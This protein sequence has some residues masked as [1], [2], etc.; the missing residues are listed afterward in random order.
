VLGSIALIWW[1]PA[2]VTAAPIWV[3]N[4]PAHVNLHF[5]R[6]FLGPLAGEDPLRETVGWFTRPHVR[7][8]DEHALDS[9]HFDYAERT[10]CLLDGCSALVIQSRQATVSIRRV[11]NVRLSSQF[12]ALHTTRRGVHAPA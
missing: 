6:H 7:T 12:S 2:G 11:R 8:R 5:D 10:R 9:L 1:R 3:N 4:R